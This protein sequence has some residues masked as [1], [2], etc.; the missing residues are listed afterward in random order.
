MDLQNTRT[1]MSGKEPENSTVA[2]LVLV[3]AARQM[4]NL[5]QSL[6]IECARWPKLRADVKANLT[7]SIGRMHLCPSTAAVAND[8]SA[9][10]PD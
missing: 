2:L 4:L 8:A 7:S 6:R 9:L 10:S 3:G 5:R 1:L